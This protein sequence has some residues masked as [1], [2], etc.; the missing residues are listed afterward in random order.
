MIACSL[1]VPALAYGLGIVT[2]AA[3]VY[4]TLLK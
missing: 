3:L 1:W 4:Y 2:L